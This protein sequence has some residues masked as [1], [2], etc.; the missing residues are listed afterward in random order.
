MGECEALLR[1]E[2]N[3]PEDEPLIVL[4][5]EEVNDTKMCYD[6]NFTVYSLDQKN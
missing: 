4:V 6:L 2:N 5:I 3:I 1:K